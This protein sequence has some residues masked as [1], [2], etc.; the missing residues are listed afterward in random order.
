MVVA[1]VAAA[2]DIAVVDIVV[3]GLAGMEGSS[4]QHMGV[5]VPYWDP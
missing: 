4:Y 1:A 3:P 5:A 2:A